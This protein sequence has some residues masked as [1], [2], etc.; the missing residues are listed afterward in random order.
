MNI[1]FAWTLKML[2]EYSIGYNRDPIV[3][4]AVLLCQS[5]DC[6]LIGESLKLSGEQRF[7]IADT[8]VDSNYLREFWKW[9][10]AQCIRMMRHRY[11][12]ASLELFRIRCHAGPDQNHELPEQV[13]RRMFQFTKEQLNPEPLINGDDLLARGYKG[14]M[15]GHVLSEVETKQLNGELYTREEALAWVS[16]VENATQ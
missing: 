16:G 6:P 4:M 5:P 14:A 13:F 3:G 1:P 10:N 15:I 9:D 11:S 12:H 7:Q 2:D 8:I